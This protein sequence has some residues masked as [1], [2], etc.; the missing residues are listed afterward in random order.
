MLVRWYTVTAPAVVYGLGLRH[1]LDAVLDRAR[2]EAAGVEVLERRAGGGLVLLDEQMLCCAICLPI[3]HPLVTT[4]LTESYRWLGERFT[5]A[6]RGIGLAE[7]RRIE[8]E[9]ARGDVAHLRAS[10]DPVDGLLLATCYG[11]L[12]PHEVVLGNAK[13]VGLAQVRRRHAALFQVGV[14]LRDQSPLS[15]FLLVPEEATRERLRAALRTRTA[16]IGSLEQA[17]LLPEADQLL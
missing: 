5:S 7:A 10:S 4:D 16:G 14:L 17:L 9:E 2:C 6:L 3:G 11:A 15:D 8:V 12:S 13:V 1:R